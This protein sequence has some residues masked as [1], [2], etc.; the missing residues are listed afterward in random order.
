MAVDPF[1]DVE[2]EDEITVPDEATESPWES[3]DKKEKVVV[4]GSNEGKVVATFKG[5]SGYDAPWVVVHADD[6]QDALSQISGDNAALFKQLLD[7]TAKVGKY[8]SGTGGGKP[9]GGG[10]SQQRGKPAGAS[11]APDGKPR[12]CDHGEMV[13]KSGIGKSNGKPWRAFF[14]PDNN[15]ECAQFLK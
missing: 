11:E 12:Y 5:G 2:A 9:S 3:T 7:E 8:F 14:C 10:Q 6:V 1:A 13:F 4:A 15:K